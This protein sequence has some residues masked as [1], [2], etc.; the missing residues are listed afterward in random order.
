MLFMDEPEKQI[1]ECSP[2]KPLVCWRY[3]DDVFMVWQHSRES[4]QQFLGFL[5]NFHPSIKF[6]T[7]YSITKVNFQFFLYRNYIKTGLYVKADRH[8]PETS[9]CHPYHV[10]SSIP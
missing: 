1:L 5:N 8:S 9:S 3:I 4:L 7:E 10:K 6:T 2:Y